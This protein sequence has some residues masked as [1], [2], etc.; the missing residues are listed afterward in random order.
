M[1]N[2]LQSLFKN[3]CANLR[4]NSRTVLILTIILFPL[5]NSLN[6]KE[7]ITVL[8]AITEDA[9]TLSYQTDEGE[10][11][12][13]SVELFKAIMTDAEIEY[14]LRVI[15]WARTY[16]RVQ[17]KENVIVFPMA[18]TKERA[19]K[20]RWI[21]EITPVNY[22]LYCLTK[23]LPSESLTLAQLKKKKLQSREA[24]LERN[25]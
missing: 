8:E 1:V 7:N 25:I 5:S 22:N 24:I 23:D 20:F 10:I 21:G 17:S 3:Y 18:W 14:E 11:G 15:P 19:S 13:Y 6:A 4:F 12:G 16:R 2:S 9:Y